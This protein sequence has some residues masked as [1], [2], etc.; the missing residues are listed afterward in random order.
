MNLVLELANYIGIIAFAISGSMKAIKKGMDLLGVLVL[1]FSTALGGGITADLLLG[2]TP[3]TNLVYLP[4]PLTAFISSLFTFIFYKVFSNVN[5]PLL[6]ADAIGLGAFASSG[7]SLAY[8]VYPS[9]L[10]V[11]MIGTI[12]AVGG[13][14]I[15]D[16]L[17]NEIPLVL[18]REF[19][20]SAAIIGSFTFFILK[21]EGV[22]EEYTIFISFV[23]TTLLR[24]VALRMKWEL[25][26][27][28]NN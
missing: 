25:P 21:Y 16:L 6:Y 13:G 5:K 9:P 2:K 1:G 14:V 12:T 8:S 7:A 18:T 17:S 23:I 28:L 4:Y 24:I 22:N 3:P 27:P 20:A 15:R 26:K 11:V 19:Y 10:L